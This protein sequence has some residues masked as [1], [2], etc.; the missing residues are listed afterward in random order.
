MS[1]GAIDRLLG[2]TEAAERLGVERRS[3]QRWIDEGE[4]V[5]HK[6]LGGHRRVL[7]RDLVAFAR[8]HKLPLRA[9]RNTV[10]L[11]DDDPDLLEGLTVR[12]RNLRPDLEIH[13]TQ[14]G[15]EAGALLAILHPALVLLDIRMPGVSGIDVCRMIRD[16]PA[17]GGCV[18][19]GVTASTRK[20]E[21]DAL[22]RAGAADVLRKPIEKG[23]LLDILDRV[24]PA[25]ATVL[26]IPRVR[27]PG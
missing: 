3:I 17:L 4:L 1:T 7:E 23:A 5:A 9:S 18:V 22:R 24:F 21:V 12:I 25:G 11:I 15:V 20:S 10:L 8:E 19:V 26:S 2:P 16:I 27:I 13:A 6:T 14:S